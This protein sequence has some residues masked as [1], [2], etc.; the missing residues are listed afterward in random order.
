MLHD[1][2]DA[3]SRLRL[4][5]RCGHP[6][7]QHGR[8]FPALRSVRTRSIRLS[9]VSTFLASSTQQI[10][11]LRASGVLSS[12][13][14]N[15]SLSARR[16]ATRSA[17]TLC[18]TPVATVFFDMSLV[19]FLPKKWAFMKQPNAIRHPWAAIRKRLFSPAWQMRA[20]V[21]ALC[22]RKIHLHALRRRS[23]GATTSFLLR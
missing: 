5:P 9:R 19:I 2:E 4:F 16:D 13:Q 15:A 3:E 10:H 7:Q 11:S 22:R 1:A 14:A 8:R 20:V 6:G 12:H 23:A 21:P 18:T 17:G